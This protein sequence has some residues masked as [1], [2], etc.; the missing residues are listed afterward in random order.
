MIKQLL[1]IF[2]G[3]TL[4]MT[5]SCK[6]F[7]EIEPEGYIR[8][9]QTFKTADDAVTAIYGLY[10]LMQ[11]LIDQIYLAGEVQGDLVVAGRGADSY[12]SEIAQNRVTPNNPY[13][14]YTKFYR[15]V[16][17]CNNAIAGLK[18]INRL[19]PVNYGNDRLNQNIAEVL[20]IRAWTYLQLVKIWEDVPFITDNITSVEQ[21]KDIAPSKSNVILGKIIKDAEDGAPFMLPLSSNSVDLKVKRSQ[22]NPDASRCL[23]AEL[24]LYAGSY[25][26][27]W[28]TI[29]NLAPY[30]YSNL[31]FKMT[32]NAGGESGTPLFAQYPNVFTATN[33][34]QLFSSYWAFFIDFD[35]SKGQKNSLLKWTNNKN[36]GI[37]AIKP[38]PNIIKAF[39]TTP[40]IKMVF[41]NTSA[42][43]YI[44]LTKNGSN[45]NPVLQADGYPVIGGYG[46]YVRGPGVAYQPDGQDTL[47]FKFLLKT[48]GVS[49][50]PYDNDPNSNDDAMFPIYRDGPV[51]LMAC[52]ILNN[53]GL[54]QQALQIMNGAYGSDFTQGTRYRVR[55]APLKLDPAS[56]ESKI[57]QVDRL[58]L[59]EKALEA[60]FEGMRWF[61]L[62]RFAKRY[63]DP[64]M[65]ANAVAKKY[66][67]SQ[68][69]A[70]IT[71]LTNKNYWSF[72]YFQRNVDVNKLLPQK[73]GY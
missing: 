39:E 14:D 57:K 70:I 62:V 22:M 2:L 4:V 25:V 18:Q 50:N 15:L 33:N 35:G 1:Y 56:T 73:P 29:R 65:I 28:E 67:V 63:N 44:D 37:Y 23:L 51:Y 72:P 13:T 12:I 68:Q 52:E 48:R 9:G 46:D 60:S 30:T 32:Q 38:S 31:L 7:V 47:I 36:G 42:G 20:Y 53:I 40:M 24:Y 3:I 64:S 45:I 43:Y 16:I 26:N 71:R 49:K 61:D 6:K 59:E 21:I 66:P 41:Q 5:I 8:D 17:A 10:G 19:D 54:S 55:V 69:S 11:P 58:I 34:S 27:A